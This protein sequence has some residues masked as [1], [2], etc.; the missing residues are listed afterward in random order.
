M[1]DNWQPSDEQTEIL[2]LASGRH[3]VLAPPGT[4]KTAMMT[5]ATKAP[6]SFT[7]P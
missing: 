3:L 6:A 2:H 1:S 7:W 5:P 4:G